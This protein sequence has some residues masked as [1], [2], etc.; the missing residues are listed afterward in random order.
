MSDRSPSR[1][2]IISGKAKLQKSKKQEVDEATLKSQIEEE[3]PE[4]IGKSFEELR[5]L[6][7][8]MIYEYDYDKSSKIQTYI[9]LQRT[10]NT[11][12]VI[13]SFQK[14]LRDEITK[15]IENY[16][17]NQE[18]AV[19]DSR[20][21][22]KRIR[23]DTE[24]TFEQMKARHIEELTD[25][26][27]EKEVEKLREKRRVS[28]EVYDLWRQSQKLA[29]V[30]EIEDAMKTKAQAD[31]LQVQQG[32]ERQEKVEMK[33][34][35]IIR[36]VLDKQKKEIEGLQKKLVSLLD[37]A[38]AVME[39][40]QMEQKKKVGVF[41]QYA[42]NKAITDGTKQLSNKKMRMTVTN[43]LTAFVKKLLKENGK[44]EFFDIQQ[45]Q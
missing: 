18:D 7:K 25:I 44:A 16:D 45:I 14:W 15:V 40:E 3:I 35:K 36:Q 31:S 37:E 13:E 21:F 4:V 33:Y 12:K 1:T 43:E 17:K 24:N 22:E 10:D 29:S 26:E 5:K 41:V 34:S 39:K 6:K 23:V 19:R 28:Q 30:D 11:G 20:E 38:E 2:S 9:E 8:D 42:L 32:E 27:T